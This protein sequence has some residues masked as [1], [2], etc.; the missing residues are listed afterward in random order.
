MDSMM[1]W[2]E[3]DNLREAPELTFPRIPGRL[4]EILR[5]IRH[6]PASRWLGSDFR[7]HRGAPQRNL[8]ATVSFRSQTAALSA[9]GWS[10]STLLFLHQDAVLPSWPLASDRVCRSCW[11]GLRS[12]A[13]DERQDVFEHLSRHV[14]FIE[15]SYRKSVGKSYTG[16]YGH[17][18]YPR[19]HRLAPRQPHSPGSWPN[20]GLYRTECSKRWFTANGRANGR[21]WRRRA[22]GDTLGMAPYHPQATLGCVVGTE[23]K[24]FAPKLNHESLALFDAEFCCE[25]NSWFTAM[26]GYRPPAGVL[27][28][29]WASSAPRGAGKVFR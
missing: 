21:T 22:N 27:T 12:K 24:I 1:I 17:E 29:R 8:I 7:S 2:H 5:L 26:R 3:W 16:N 23:L 9:G 18:L 15:C 19:H 14:Y 4:S 11:R 13:R 20:A 10:R 28:S 25:T 6:S